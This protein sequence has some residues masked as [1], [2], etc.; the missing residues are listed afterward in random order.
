[1]DLIDISLGAKKAVAMLEESGRVGRSLTNK[2]WWNSSTVS[3]PVY[4]FVASE[5]LGGLCVVRENSINNFVKPTD[6]DVTVRWDDKD[7]YCKINS[8]ENAAFIGN[9]SLSGD[10]NNTGE[11]FFI[12]IDWDDATTLII[13]ETEGEHYLNICRYYKTIV[14]IDPKYLPETAIPK[15]INLD[16]Y[17]IGEVILSLFASG[18]GTQQLEDV[19]TF[20][21]D[22][23]TNRLLRLTQ[24]YQLGTSS[25]YT[26][27]VDQS[28]RVRYANNHDKVAYICFSFTAYAGADNVHTIGVSIYNTGAGASVYVE[29]H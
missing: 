24:N 17:G 25:S 29:V 13:S 23:A 18:G 12:I 20:W 21:S 10:G 27:E 9:Q 16:D 8:M 14:P 28:V 19:G 4:V 22:I 1:M 6:F 5:E 15:V 2:E 3:G 7:Y 11:P 26:F